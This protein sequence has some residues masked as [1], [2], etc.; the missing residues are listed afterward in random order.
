MEHWF[1][2]FLTLLIELP[3]VIIFFRDEPGYALLIGFLL[4]LFTWPLLHIFLFYTDIHIGILEFAVAVIESIGY[5]VM[6]KCRW[7]KA[8]TLAFV[9]NTLSY[10][11]GLLLNKFL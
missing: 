2:F 5:C 3:L 7:K 1:Y 8:I 9:A 11:L 6:L 10:G 4:N